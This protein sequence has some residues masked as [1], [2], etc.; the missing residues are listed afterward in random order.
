M[1][2]GHS[3]GGNFAVYAAAF[4]NKRTRVKI[5]RVY[6]NDGPGFREEILTSPEYMEIM[7]RIVSIVPEDSIVGVLLGTKEATHIV[8]SSQD[9]IMAHEAL[10]WQLYG[11]H[12]VETG[13]RSSGSEFVQRTI[14]RWISMLSDEE[15]EAFVDQLFDLITNSGLTSVESV[16]SGKTRAAFGF[17][18]TF[19]QIP[20]EEQ[21]EFADVVMKLIKSGTMEAASKRRREE[22]E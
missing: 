21:I 4:C 19:R 12:F 1:T 3:K 5:L 14:A 9:G 7:P 2:G 6:S 22:P 20:R 8:K 18:R 13:K 10:S 17:L 16:L 11:K 15:R